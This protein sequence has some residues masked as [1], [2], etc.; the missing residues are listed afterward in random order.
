MQR[1]HQFP[2]PRPL[3][4]WLAA[5]A[6]SDWLARIIFECQLCNT[7][8]GRIPAERRC[9]TV[10]GACAA[11]SDCCALYTCKADG[12]GALKCTSPVQQ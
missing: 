11:D 1:D 12:G 7:P 2:S 3:R 10:G 6:E 4:E 5:S 9:T 8:S